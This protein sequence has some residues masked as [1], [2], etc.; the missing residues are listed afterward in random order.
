MRSFARSLVCSFIRLVYSFVRLLFSLSTVSF[1]Y[2]FFFVRVPFTLSFHLIDSHSSHS[3]A[4]K[5]LVLRLFVFVVQP[6]N[7]PVFVCRVAVDAIQRSDTR[8]HMPFHTHTYTLYSIELYMW[9][10]ISIYRC[11]TVHAY[12]FS[13]FWLAIVYSAA[14]NIQTHTFTYTNRPDFNNFSFLYRYNLRVCVCYSRS[15]SSDCLFF[16]LVLLHFALV[17]FWLFGS[18]LQASVIMLR[19]FKNSML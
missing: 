18:F 5:Y 2:S 8:P 15:S 16:L 17:C 14:T 10:Y 6:N 12:H 4:I 7:K 1:F 19:E 11:L 3:I 9:P 13:T